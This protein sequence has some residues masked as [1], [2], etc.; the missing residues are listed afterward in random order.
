MNATCSNVYIAQITEQDCVLLDLR[1]TGEYL[2]LQ[3]SAPLWTAIER[4][5]P[6]ADIITSVAE[7]YPT[8]PRD[9]VVAE[10]TAAIAQ[11]TR[12]GWLRPASQAPQKGASIG[13]HA[14]RFSFAHYE[15]Q[16]LLKQCVVIIE[17]GQFFALVHALMALP[18]RRDPPNQMVHH[19]QEAVTLATY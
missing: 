16:A 8:T 19:L 1:R 5:T 11:Y 17:Q 2:L 7:H 3:G 10:V 14:P 18:T 6:L 15:A 4:H 9:A 13:M 12:E